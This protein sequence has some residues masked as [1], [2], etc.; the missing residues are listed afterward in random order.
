MRGPSLP[1]PGDARLRHWITERSAAALAVALVVGDDPGARESVAAALLVDPFLAAWAIPEKAAIGDTAAPLSAIVDEFIARLRTELHDETDA[2]ATGA[3]APDSAER[4]EMALHCA[5]AA[6][7]AQPDND[8][9][10]V[11]A[12]SAAASGLLDGGAA[13]L[14]RLPP[15]RCAPSTGELLERVAAIPAAASRVAAARRHWEANGTTLGRQLPAIAARLARIERLERDAAHTLETERLDAM[16]ELAAGA[17]HEVNNPLAVISGRAQLLLRGERDPER[18]HDLAVIHA[19]ARR[20]YEMIADMM[21]FARPPRPALERCDA[22]LLAAEVVAEIAPA[23]ARRGVAVGQSGAESAMLTADPTQL[24]VAVRA[25]CDNALE[26]LD[27]GGR[28]SIDVRPLPASGVAD[29]VQ[30]IVRD[31]GPGIEP[32]VRRRMFDP[33]YSGRPAGRGLGMGL[34]KCWRIVA[35]HGGR[36]DV[37][38]E[39]GYGAELTIL[40]PMCGPPA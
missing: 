29:H 15:E 24:K 35:E 20:V 4:A 1:P 8:A 33:F 31:N 23:A 39:P 7:L 22:A 2:P 6:A 34:S 32:A 10:Y 36:I 18:R 16:A 28:L 38:S 3:C 19:Q 25:L 40:L 27:D 13:A 12:L 30:L 5:A 9:R 11:A 37:A 26:S 21:L 14:H 17:G